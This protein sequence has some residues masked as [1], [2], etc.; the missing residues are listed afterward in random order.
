MA[1]TVIVTP[2][3]RE[4]SRREFRLVVPPGTDLHGV[5][6]DSKVRIG[7]IDSGQVVQINPLIDDRPLSEMQSD[8]HPGANPHS[9]ITGTELRL[10]IEYD[11][12]QHRTD[13]AQYQRD[14]RRLRRLHSEGWYVIRVTKDDLRGGARGVLAHIA[15]VRAVRMAAAPTR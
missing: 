1:T 12:E 9:R 11:G 7:G 8:D 10:A 15:H 4:R 5:S 3:I 2:T 6:L 13:D 14:I